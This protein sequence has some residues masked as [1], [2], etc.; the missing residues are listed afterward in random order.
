MTAA[1]KLNRTGSYSNFCRRC[2]ERVSV[3]RQRALIDANRL[4]CKD[5]AGLN[6]S[7]CLYNL[8]SIGSTSE[9]SSN[10]DE[11]GDEQ[12]GYNLEKKFTKAVGILRRSPRKNKPMRCQDE[13]NNE[14]L[15]AF[16]QSSDE[17]LKENLDKMI[18]SD[19]HSK[20][21]GTVKRMNRS[22]ILR[23][24]VGSSKSQK[25]KASFDTES[26]PARL[27]ASAKKQ[28]LNMHVISE[29]NESEKHGKLKA[30]FGEVDG[31]NMRLAKLYIVDFVEN[32]KRQRYWR[33][34]LMEGL[35]SNILE[36]RRLR[37][38]HVLTYMMRTVRHL[39][40]RGRQNRSLLISD[41]RF[42]QTMILL[43]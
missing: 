30:N 8:S 11:S 31:L 22:K 33:S 40:E 36:A 2:I 3:E 10:S 19:K 41:S 27:E 29:S 20:F 37:R 12:E 26:P 16:S 35:V 24:F 21:G 6:N 28:R 1:E 25:R 9:E 5:L 39:P 7:L 34:Y 15:D 42:Q 32:G 38:S 14:N 4:Q 43:I 18:N 13:S 23:I 17:K